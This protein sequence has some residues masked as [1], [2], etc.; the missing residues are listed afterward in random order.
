ME[1]LWGVCVVVTLLVQAAK[2]LAQVLSSVLLL[3]LPLHLTM[4]IEWES[5]GV[6]VLL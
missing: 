5:C 1:K 6:Y 4:Q 2:L 3:R